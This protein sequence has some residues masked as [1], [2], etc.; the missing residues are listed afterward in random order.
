V[1]ESDV[2]Y[3]TVWV[4][5][6]VE[7]GR[8]VRI[9]KQ[10]TSMVF[11]EFVIPPD[12]TGPDGRLHIECENRDPNTLLFPLEDGLEVL[13]P[14]GGFAGNYVRALLVVLCWLAWLTALGL[15]SSSFLSF[16]IAALFAMTLLM[17]ALSGNTFGGGLTAG[18]GMFIFSRRELAREQVAA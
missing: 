1:L 14:Q 3:Q 8:S 2:T 4:I 6:H 17:V 5:G 15:A 9:P 10:L 16:I 18:A 13:F 12:L 11:H 7:S